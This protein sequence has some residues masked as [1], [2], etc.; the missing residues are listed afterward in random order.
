MRTWLCRNL[1][2]LSQGDVDVMD[3]L[4]LS[5]QG[6]RNSVQNATKRSYMFETAVPKL[7]SF[8]AGKKALR[9]VTLPRQVRS[10]FGTDQRPLGK[11]R[12]CSLTTHCFE[13]FAAR[14]LAPHFAIII[15][16]NS[17]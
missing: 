16:T 2:R 13:A 9:S 6:K 8:S 3:P 7:S 1:Q 11:L 14:P 15:F 5:L 17:A 10:L 12:P 4:P